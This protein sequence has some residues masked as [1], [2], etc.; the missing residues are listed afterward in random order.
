MNAY[1]SFFTTEDNIKAEGLEVK[2]DRKYFKL[3]RADRSHT[4]SGDRGHAVELT[5]AAYRKVPLP[6]GA[7]L[8]S[9][10][11]VLVELKLTSKNDYEHL[12]FEDY[13]PA[14]LEAVAVRS[15]SVTGETVA[16][17]EV[18]DER[19]VF[20]LSE[21]T[22][23]AMTLRYRLRAEIPGTFSAMPTIGFGMYAPEIRANS[24]EWTVSVTERRQP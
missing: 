9:G 1:L 22:Q 13:K 23:G 18:R 21:L 19:V 15:G 2:V 10:D 3:E 11:I 17:M 6:S 20:F 14:G 12:A 5:E 4:V 7:T 16:H 8:Q 24:D